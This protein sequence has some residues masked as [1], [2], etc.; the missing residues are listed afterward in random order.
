MI[1]KLKIFPRFSFSV[2]CLVYE[3]CNEKFVV[4]VAHPR[5]VSE[6]DS[7]HILPIYSSWHQVFWEKVELASREVEIAKEKVLSVQRFESIGM[8]EG[9]MCVVPDFKK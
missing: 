5:I 1:L 2:S 3:I 8:N 6:I 4:A 7:F 9:Q